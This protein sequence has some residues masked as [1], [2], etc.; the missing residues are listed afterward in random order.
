MRYRKLQR[1]EESVSQL[2]FGAM[3]LP[4]LAGDPPGDGGRIDEKAA[5]KLLE[6][7]YAGGVNYFDTAYPYHQGESE[8][9]VGKFLAESG[10]RNQIKLA[11]KLPAWLIKGSADFDR[12]FNEQLAR[13]QTEQIDFYLLHS[14]NRRTIPKLLAWDIAAFCDRLKAQGRVRYIGFSFHDS[15]PYFEQLLDAYDFDFVQIQLNY[16]D[17]DY[18]AGLRGLREAAARGLD[19]M[20]MEPLRGGQLARE[21]VGDL[22]D[23]WDSFGT[24]LTPAQLGLKYLYNMPEVTTVLSGM[25]TAGQ[26]GE[27]LATAAAFSCGDLT[28]KEG[29]MIAALQAFYK[30]RVQ[31][32][33]TACQYCVACPQDIPI[34]TAFRYLNEAHMYGDP[35]ASKK[36]YEAN[37]NAGQRAVDCIR[38]GKCVPACPQGID[39]PGELARTQRYFYKD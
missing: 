20:I 36:K 24:D 13:L 12:Y 19:V 3:R 35:A 14:L 5:V 26:V 7:A 30:D 23:L 32:P 1:H 2:G 25:S 29:Q 8:P 27:N 4:V 34:W 28:K 38:C 16:V 21:P 15:Y 33:C 6:Q 39:I 9:F 31:V 10:L 18:Q 22:K 17:E 11:T 37:T